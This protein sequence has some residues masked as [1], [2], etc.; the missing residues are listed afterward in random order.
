M[1]P[2]ETCFHRLSLPTATWEMKDL[3]PWAMF[4]LFLKHTAGR[5]DQSHH[6][7]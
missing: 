6:Q 4:V 1:G 5:Y 7:Q 2:Q 3:Y